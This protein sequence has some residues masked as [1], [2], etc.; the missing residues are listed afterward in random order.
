MHA[1]TGLQTLLKS[2]H[3]PVRR[4]LASLTGGCLNSAQRP[5]IH[6]PLLATLMRPAPAVLHAV[7]WALDRQHAAGRGRRAPQLALHVRAMS[8]YRAKN[9]TARETAEQM[10][11]AL[12]CV[13][14]AA[15]ALRPGTASPHRRPVSAVLVSSS[16]ELRNQLLSELASE[17]ARADGAIGAFV[18][19]W[20][21]YLRQA[22]QPIAAALGR[23][24][25]EATAFCAGV[26]ASESHRCNRS[27][28]LRDWGPEPHWVAVVELLLVSSVTHTVVGAGFPYFKVC[29]TFAQIGAALA[30]A[31]PEWLC[32]RRDCAAGGARPRGVRLV[33]ATRVLSTDWGSSAWRDLNATQRRGTDMVVDCGEPSCVA[34]PLQPELWTGLRGAC[35]DGD[36]FGK[37]QVLFG[38]TPIRPIHTGH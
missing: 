23:S 26:N 21:R 31:A 10:S 33:C 6:G 3:E 36:T 1:F 29:N 20:R 27:A 35:P 7:H 24:E 16:P 38:T 30:D 34:T 18:F 8:D 28:H 32:A 9:L 11:N 13:A 15:A 22:P 19:D 2:A 17:R 37:P 4:R 5:N 25:A 14:R 12:S